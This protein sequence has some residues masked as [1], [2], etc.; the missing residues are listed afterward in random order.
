MLCNRPSFTTVDL[1]YDFIGAF[2]PNSE[3]Q[4]HERDEKHK[5]TALRIF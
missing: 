1:F 5:K 2:S 4:V 3:M